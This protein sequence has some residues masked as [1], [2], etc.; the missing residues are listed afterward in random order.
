MLTLCFLIFNFMLITLTLPP[1][2]FD[3]NPDHSSYCG[4][5]IVRRGRA[6]VVVELD[7]EGVA[8]LQERANAALERGLLKP[9]LEP[10]LASMRRTLLLCDRALTNV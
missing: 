7:R 6:S 8:R 1:L 5:R 2:F 10:L 9:T 4:A 3:S